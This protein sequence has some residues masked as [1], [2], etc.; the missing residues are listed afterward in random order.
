MVAWLRSIILNA[1]NELALASMA[2]ARR[3]DTY[4]HHGPL[5][6]LSVP[7]ASL[8]FSRPA[9]TKLSAPLSVVT[10]KYD[11]PFFQLLR[12]TLSHSKG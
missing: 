11:V 7:S 10:A 6:Q 2:E 8:F 3:E 9:A 4:C 5:N 1:G 12:G